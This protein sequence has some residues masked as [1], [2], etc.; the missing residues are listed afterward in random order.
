[1][2]GTT[3]DAGFFSLRS[4][5]GHLYAGTYGTPRCYVLEGDR[6]RE[7]TGCL[8]SAGESLFDMA[9]LGEVL[10]GATENTGQLFRFTGEGWESA[11]RAGGDWNNSYAIIEYRG[12]VWT[13]FNEFPRNRRTLIVHGPPWRTDVLDGFHHLRFGVL[14]ERLYAVGSDVGAGAAMLRYDFD[15]G[16][17]RVASL[18]ADFGMKMATIGGAL[19]FGTD[20]PAVV[21]RFDGRRVSPVMRATGVD[22]LPQVV[23][24]RDAMY[25]VG[26]VGWRART[27]TA[28]LFE[29]T[30][31]A[32]V[33]VE[34]GE[35][36]GWC[37][38]SH[39]G[40]LYVG[41]RREGGGGKVYR[42]EGL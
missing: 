1:V 2:V 17:T 41:T 15:T 4:W 35:P 32:R 20:G 30:D 10:Y 23:G 19:Y 27:G 34:F 33:V 5:G 22:F 42:V 12:E 37:L 26:A 25:A 9:P 6:W 28:R 13:G 8:A 31:R 21:W 38:A 16:W 14:D 40:A 3:P 39:R 18:A 24:H 29:V 11:F 36:E 7:V